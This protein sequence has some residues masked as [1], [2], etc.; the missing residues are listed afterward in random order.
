M[1]AVTRNQ[2]TSR[3]ANPI[4]ISLSQVLEV[5]IRSDVSRIGDSSIA[6]APLFSGGSVQR[7]YCALLTQRLIIDVILE[8]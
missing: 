6:S 5:L 4:T 7:S 2:R 3:I 1:N 8:H